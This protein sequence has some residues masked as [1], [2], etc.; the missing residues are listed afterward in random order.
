MSWVRGIFPRNI[1][2]NGWRGSRKSGTNLLRDIA[3]ERAM[4]FGGA[5]GRDGDP[6]EKVRATRQTTNKATLDQ[7]TNK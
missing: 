2:Y 3:S 4:N 6:K 5:S 7:T 1:F